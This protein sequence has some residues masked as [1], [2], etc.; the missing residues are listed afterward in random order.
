[1]TGGLNATTG[2][3]VF[4]VL[5]AAEDDPATAVNRE[6]WKFNAYGAGHVSAYPN[7]NGVIFDSFGSNTQKQV[8][9]P[10]QPLDQWH[11]Y[12]VS[13]RTGEW[14]A[15]ING[16]MQQT[17]AAGDIQFGLNPSFLGWSNYDTG[18]FAG[19]IAEIMIYDRVL[20]VTERAAVENYLFW[21]YH[22]FSD[23]VGTPVAS[24][25]PGFYQDE[26]TVTL[27]SYTEGAT[28][29][30]TTD[31]SA[32]T[33]GSPVYIAPLVRQASTP[34]RARAFK[35]GLNPSNVL[36]ANYY[37]GVLAGNGDGLSAEYYSGPDFTGSTVLQVNETLDFNWSN[38]S[39]H[40]LIP[41]DSFSARWTA[42]LVP[43]FTEDYTLYLSSDF[44]AR[45]W[46]DDQL[47]IDRW[48]GGS[49]AETSAV[50]SMAA[51]QARALRVEY[52]E[53]TGP[54]SVKLSWSSF[55]TPKAVIPKS[56]LNSG[57]PFPQ[58]V[59]T[60][61]AT[62]AGGSFSGS[63][64]ITLACTTPNAAIRYTRDGSFPTE[65]ST[66]YTGP[67]TISSTT[68]LKARAF[69]SGSNDSGLFQ[70]TYTSDNTGPVISSISFNGQP[71]A[72]STITQSG[73]VT[74]VASD[75]AGVGRVDFL[76]D[77]QPIGSDSDP[78]N[79][80]T[81]ALNPEDLTDTLHTLL[82]VA[83]DSLDSST[84][85]P[86]DFT[87]QLGVPIAPVLQKPANGA[88]FASPAV[89]VTGVAVAEKQVQ[90]YH[91]G[92]A[93][94]S[95]VVAAIDGSFR[96][97]ATLV[98][99]ANTFNARSINRAGD[100]APS[101]TVSVTLDSTI[102]PAPDRIRITAG[103]NGR[104]AVSWDSPPGSAIKGYNVYRSPVSFTDKAAPTTTKLNTGLLTQTSLI[105]AP[106]D[107]G[108]YFYRVTAVGPSNLESLLSAEVF[109]KCDKS[110]PQITNVQWNP[111]GRF[112]VATGRI[113]QGRVDVV[114]TV[115]EELQA[116][117]FFSLVPGGGSPISIPLQLNGG[118]VYAGSFEVRADTPSGPAQ[119]VA[120]FRDLV[121][122]RGSVIAQGATIL[123]DTAGPEVTALA[124][125]PGAAIKNVETSPVEVTLTASL[126]SSVKAGTKPVFKYSLSNSGITPVEIT[127]VQPSGETWIANFTLPPEAGQTTETLA[128]SFSAID[129]LENQG[130]RIAARSNF[131]VYQGD[132]PGLD[133]PEAL[134]AESLA[135]GKIRLHWRAVEDAADYQI[136]WRPRGSAV[137][138]QVVRSGGNITYVHDLHG[139]SI[140]DG[141]YEYAVAT[142]R[143]AGTAESLG[144]LSNIVWAVS[145]HVAPNAPQT[146]TLQVVS[147]GVKAQW[148][149]PLPVGG[150][151]EPVTYALY[152]AAQAPVPT[153]SGA[154][155]ILDDIDGLE[156]I[157]AA[158]T[159][160][161]RFYVAVA[162]D[163]VG[164]ES[165]PSNTVTQNVAL[166]PV[167]N[168]VVTLPKGEVPV[169][170]WSPVPAA[171]GGY[172]ISVGEGEGGT[173]LNPSGPVTTTTITDSSY[174]Q[175]ER[176]YTVVA[177]DDLNQRSLPR[178]I[179]LPLVSATLAESAKIE[180]GFMNRFVYTVRND[181]T[182]PVD[183]VRIKTAVGIHSHSSAE[184]SVA[185]GESKEVPVV[186]GGYADL[187][188]GTVTANSQLEIVPNA[189]EK[190]VILDSHQVLVTNGKYV[191]SVL[192]NELTRGG[193]A[194][195]QFKFLNPSEEE[196]EIVTATGSG[197]NASGEVRFNLID[198][199]GNLLSTK[200][201]KMATG[202]DVVMLSSGQ[203]VVRIPA[204]YEFTSNPVGLP[205]PNNA[206][207]QVAVQ[208]VI[209]TIHFHIGKADELSLTGLTAKRETSLIETAYSGEVTAVS[210]QSS[211][212][213]S[214]IVISGHALKREDNTPAP[215]APLLLKIA[216]AGA[217]RT[218]KVTA[219]TDG[220]FSYTYK[221][222]STER[223]GIYSTWVTHPDVN[224]GTM[225][226]QFTITRLL[227]NPAGMHVVLPRGY[228]HA[229]SISATAGEG[230]SATNLRLEYR[231]EDQ[232]GGVPPAG[233]NVNLSSPIT[234]LPSGTKGTLGFTLHSNT[235]Q[236]GTIILR[237]ISNE[238]GTGEWAKIPVKYDFRE[239]TPILDA[240]GIVNVG[241]AP[242]ETVS[243]AVVL[244]NRGLSNLEG[245]KL[246]LVDAA[247]ELPAP[248][249]ASIASAR[250]IA[251]IPAD[252]G[253]IFTDLNTAEVALSFSPQESTSQGD[254]T[255]LLRVEADNH[256]TVDVPVQVAVTTSETGQVLLKLVDLYTG[257]IDA[258]TGQVRQGVQGAQVVLQNTLVPS[259]R[260]TFTSDQFGDAQPSEGQIPVGQ[261]RVEITSPAHES[262]VSSLWVR[263]G[264]TTEERITLMVS[265]VTVN[266][267]VVPTTIQDRY[268][269]VLNST[270]TTSVPAPVVT[271]TPGII[272]IPDMCAGEVFTGEAELTNHGLV[273]A[274]SLKMTFPKSDD[275]F[276]FELLT[277]MPDH[278]EAHETIRIR[279][280]M[281]CLRALPGSCPDSP[282]NGTVGGN[283]G[284]LVVVGDGGSGQPGGPGGP[285][286]PGEPQS[287]DD[288]PS[289]G[290]FVG[291]QN[292]IV[293]ETGAYC[294]NG[295]WYRTTALH[296]VGS[297]KK[298][299]CGTWA[300]GATYGWFPWCYGC[301]GVGKVQPWRPWAALGKAGVTEPCP[302]ETP[303][304]D[305]ECEKD[306][307]TE[308]GSW[309][310]NIK[311]EYMDSAVDFMV[312]VPNGLI[313]IHRQFDA[314][315][316]F[317][318][319]I[320]LGQQAIWHTWLGYKWRF[321]MFEP[322]HLYDEIGYL[323]GSPGTLM[324]QKLGM[325]RYMG[326]R[327][328]RDTEGNFI[329]GDSKLQLQPNG[330][331]KLIEKSGSWTLFTVSGNKAYISSF[332]VRDMT[333]ATF[334][335]PGPNPSAI[336]DVTGREVATL[337]WQGQNLSRITD[338]GGREVEYTYDT[339]V[340]PSGY[341]KTVTDVDGRES[342][343]FYQE[344]EPPPYAAQFSWW[345]PTMRMTKKDIPDHG[346]FTI[347][348]EPQIVFAAAPKASVTAIGVSSSSG[349][350]ST[351]S[352][353]SPF[354]YRPIAPVKSVKQ[355]DEG[356][357]RTFSYRFDE[358][359]K[360]YYT[361]IRHPDDKVEERYFDPSGRVQ[362][363]YLNGFLIQ[364]VFYTENSKTTVDAPGRATVEV[365]D[366]FG[367]IVSLTTP[368]GGTTT[369]TYRYGTPD[370][371]KI[372][373][374]DGVV[375]QMKY[376][377]RGNMWEVRQAMGTPDERVFQTVYHPTLPLPTS[378]TQVH[379][380]DATK[381]ITVEIEYDALGRL[382]KTFDP[383]DNY[384]EILEYNTADQPLRVRDR[385]GKVW[386]F[387][388][389]AKNLLKK[390]T[391]PLN[392]SKQLAYND[393]Q[394]VIA[395]IDEK[396]NQLDFTY[397]KRGNLTKAT[398]P[399]GRELS[400]NYDSQDR[401]A[402]SEDEG[403]FPLTRL[404][405]DMGRLKSLV[406]HTGTTSFTYESGNERFP[407]PGP[408]AR[409]ATISFPNLT[410]KLFHDS[411]GR[412][413][414]E[415]D[416]QDP[417]QGVGYTYDPMGRLLAFTDEEE[418]T[419]HYRYN[420]HGELIAEIK[421]NGENISYGYDRFGNMETYTVGGP[422]GES[423][424]WA[425]TYDKRGLK[426]SERTPGQFLTQYEY[427]EEEKLISIIRPSGKK[428]GYG[429]DDD[430][431]LAFTRLYAAGDHQQPV[432]TTSFSYDPRGLLE[433]Y[434]DGITSGTLTYD[435]YGNKLTEV[436]DYGS[437]NLSHTYTYNSR[438]LKKTYR[439]P[440]GVTYQYD[441]DSADRISSV[442]IPGQ[443]SV[444]YNNY[445]EGGP[446]MIQTPGG[447]KIAL[448]YDRY[449][450]LRSIVSTNFLGA[451]ALS[452]GYD[453]TRNGKIDTRTR[454]GVLEAYGYDDVD[455]ILTDA[456]GAYT[457]DWAG[458]RLTSPNRP[459]TASYDGTSPSLGDNRLLSDGYS[460]FAYDHDGN[461]TLKSSPD[462]D[463]T[464][465]Y[466]ALGHL[467][468]VSKNGQLVATYEYD[469]WGRRIWKEINGGQRTYYHYADEGLVGEF[470]A[471]GIAIKTYGYEPESWWTADPMFL[472]QGDTYFW[473]VNDKLGT[474][475][476]LVDNNGFVVWSATH[477][478]FGESIVG[479]EAV[480]NNLRFPGQYFDAETGLHYNWQRYYDAETGRYLS[481]D[482]LQDGTNWYVYAIS[483]PLVY[484]D[485]TGEIIPLLLGLG[486]RYI[487]VP[488]AVNKAGNW[489]I[490]NVL[491]CKFRNLARALWSI[492]DMVSLA[493]GLKSLI[494]EGLGGLKNAWN[495]IRNGGLKNTWNALKQTACKVFRDGCFV[496]GTKIATGDGPRGIETIK[497][498]DVV[499]S[500]DE[501]SGK[502]AWRGVKRVFCRYAPVIISLR[503]ASGE[504]IE[505]TPEHPFLVMESSAVA[506]ASPASGGVRWVDASDLRAGDAL[507][508][509]AGRTSVL[510][511]ESLGGRIVY[512]IE[513]EDLHTYL[514][515]EGKIAVHNVCAGY[516]H[517][518]PRALGNM[519][520]YG[521][522]HLTYLNSAKHTHLQNSL[523]DFLKDRR[524]TLA[525]GKE[526]NMYARKG[527]TGATIQSN[528]SKPEREAALHDFYSTFEG[529]RYYPAFKME[530]NAAKKKGW[531]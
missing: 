195:V 384:F 386:K 30:Y 292:C 322:L 465:Q 29:R 282:D 20:S 450:R 137:N 466:D 510:S 395:I 472:K 176:I 484:T 106:A 156:A 488:W 529:G 369:Y 405:D 63:A 66:L 526:I 412:V 341:I 77:G 42:Q 6:L 483:N 96:V 372:V 445:D 220:S 92:A 152:R 429:Y 437:F 495:F 531:W 24:P 279:Y 419:T 253:K 224:A 383:L 246:S 413:I 482:P 439:S 31:G 165:A 86:V 261:Y 348:Y 187:Q 275:Y 417:Q 266:W 312:R 35:D 520:P 453:Y 124:I 363:V 60:P 327:F 80:F 389:T 523:N 10:T 485:P 191:V 57:L 132:L 376:D 357:T 398:G 375:T 222:D 302:P 214:D 346:E 512:N 367:N 101:A 457:Y 134:V 168:L 243:Q 259:V 157:D 95:P 477:K 377:E 126:S 422:N 50:V 122:N 221:P 200:P 11:L 328:V 208:L 170:S 73:T 25:N 82:V 232:P 335:N 193:S 254:Y 158:P 379:P 421:P 27:S 160:V 99:G 360:E 359:T 78:Q 12:N 300:G 345:V 432:R 514:V 203:S 313:T 103:E 39:P 47:V 330:Q 487:V 489:L 433:S 240:P 59:D 201:V 298:R 175:G 62:P 276:R 239:T 334:T 121:G 229:L 171:A 123:L 150:I 307:K 401:L 368:E 285:G 5:K 287:P 418:R 425:Y 1:V 145:D 149:E 255:F 9:N 508:T 257:E 116:A 471:S 241:V 396:G 186:V 317:I 231:A 230:T 97:E 181:S 163:A 98:E 423:K 414:R 146:L 315:G 67:I 415:E 325:I 110:A 225:Q 525:S 22:L 356:A 235:I 444:T 479:V 374:P 340:Q 456:S 349:G 41:A 361:E 87:V 109:G 79:N 114:V 501:S 320:G 206:P 14:T 58:T 358:S 428:V 23:T 115:N 258:G 93:L 155:P 309:V 207:V 390:I 518:I 53:N 205:V 332:G 256:P 91:N 442:T 438:G 260:F 280:R 94:G 486:F 407:E 262:H 52:R 182:E 507:Q 166:L 138:W 234:Q 323:L 18:K 120:S 140:P 21:K 494:G 204:G 342:E 68:T 409:F 70:S 370:P 247:S 391:S 269:I 251:V 172:D 179:R 382:Q 278:L 462:G 470:N 481:V 464:Y 143:Q 530:L 516:H 290:C 8:G 416:V 252:N 443:G 528:F 144:Q 365:Y 127:D 301:G 354:S 13:A 321:P 505:T 28:V 108:I 210:P 440:D 397:D 524:T 519:T 151:L 118:G 147:T 461:T 373:A 431:K 268:E 74:I 399:G 173:L 227:L 270:F 318:H 141:E 281:T 65:T 40:V 61:V 304:G 177:I 446:R 434:D 244:R 19:G 336:K 48:N 527:N 164:N 216:N 458:N 274:D 513:V 296:C 506:G 272:N 119:A 15:R 36:S 56:Q 411:Q 44:G 192:T 388:Y 343:Y 85:A 294:A 371:T 245:V 236:Q 64:M 190:V 277:E 237:A 404:Y 212:G 117:P 504:I 83:Y 49:P 16:Q 455:R 55:S 17:F 410:Q 403:K 33:I 497:E 378:V 161:E 263:R 387:E 308:T 250:E 90:V 393:R 305:D 498:G 352:L 113:G 435:D 248:G 202:T 26:V 136:H 502:I 475:Q 286:E 295:T 337:Q 500:W 264:V 492:F 45:L 380:T 183:H 267:S 400:F 427:N 130:T 133:S 139:Q 424:T 303:D 196:I 353:A 271:L 188:A 509:E 480:V 426:L 385:R 167:Q 184:F 46:L 2:G 324:V 107:D 406:D 299:P 493:R 408:K 339:S 288:D 43:R 316:E 291:Y 491:P 459:A 69:K 88:I 180:R 310:H 223:G 478:T 54:A 441:Y 496:A 521:S 436:I 297:L 76:L 333:T 162:V 105:D 189:G 350:T 148:Q 503:V 178:T 125:A 319:Q 226:Q 402:R 311:R 217:E 326:K 284:G 476:V 366:T 265:F 218:I 89:K 51:G 71:L 4:V 169:I 511:T 32:P 362:R 131:E 355:E 473:Y 468:S 338:A 37:V 142:I 420:V 199:A 112:D 72:N 111:A 273:R 449:D 249:W 174:D 100:S 447:N 7:P 238:T 3:E 448:S 293:V 490:D 211:N 128:I 364:E 451:Q 153:G 154:T 474:P 185:P 351:A 392:H 102:P 75:P 104:L 452:I 522:K 469:P 517:L 463:W 329:H 430:G 289:T 197:A 499:Q 228:S 331:Y 215:G 344:N 209:D 159:S 84:S 129:D 81:V 454:N 34:I 242:G 135:G 213:T 194:Q 233:L 347:S 306:N 467:T 38:G 381:S 283:P 460:T 314:S 515:G 394:D 219:G 198:A